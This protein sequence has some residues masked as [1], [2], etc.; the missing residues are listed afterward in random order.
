MTFLRKHDGSAMTIWVDARSA[1]QDEARSQNAAKRDLS[2]PMRWPG[3]R[4]L[5]PELETRPIEMVELSARRVGSRLQEGREASP[6]PC[7]S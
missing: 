5:G 4:R 3:A 1:S 6:R 7:A 2:R